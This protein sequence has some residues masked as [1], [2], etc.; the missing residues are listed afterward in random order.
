MPFELRYSEAAVGQLRKLRAFDRAMILREIEQ[1]LGVNPTLE[2]KAKIKLLRPPAPT[3][4][5]LRVGEF[6]VF[7]DVFAETVNIIQVLGKDDCIAYL[8]ATS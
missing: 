6:R 7:Y 2:S 5:R 3:Q 8:E 1:V 4:Y